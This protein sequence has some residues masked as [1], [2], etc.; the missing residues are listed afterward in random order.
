MPQFYTILTLLGQAELAEAI[1]E[2]RQVQLTH[3]AVGDGGGSY[4]TPSQGQTTLVNERYRSE[5]NSISQDIANPNWIIV[6]LIIP[7]TIGGWYIREAGIFSSTGNLF[8]VGIIPET[9][10]PQFSEGAGKDLIVRMILEVS[11]ASAVTLQVDPSVV[12]ASRQY[13]NNYVS[14]K[15]H[16]HNYSL[17]S[18]RDIRIKLQEHISSDNE[19]NIPS[20]IANAMQNHT[21]D[22]NAHPVYGRMHIHIQNTPSSMWIVQHDFNTSNIPVAR[23]YSETSEEVYLDG[24]CGSGL[25]CGSGAT[26]GSE[27]AVEV[28]VLTD[29]PYSDILLISQNK[30]AIRFSQ[31]QSGKA[32]II[33]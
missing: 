4:Y 2:G 32:V 13:V 15:F 23:A 24:Y 28:P 18:H 27:T 12:L 19:H 20:Q 3:M 21:S 29:I 26:C 25:Y 31:P 1:A 16:E 14:D 22:I 10:K 9:Y 33:I 7:A 30:L 17:D 11:N 6:E 8:A 5:I